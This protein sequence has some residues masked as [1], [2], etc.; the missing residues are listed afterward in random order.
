M[1]DT[2]KLQKVLARAGIASR[3]EIERW[4]DAGR[5][6]V[7]N[8]VAQLG[9]RVGEDDKIHVDDKLVKTKSTLAPRILLY[10]KP[11]GE[12]CSRGDPEGRKTIFANLPELKAARWISI[13][14][15][16]FNSAGLLLLTTDGEL[17]NKLMHP[18]NNIE[19]EYA[20]RVYGNVTNEKLTQ[21]Q[22]GVQLEDGPARFERILCGEG[23]G[24]NQ[25]YYV[26]LKE[27]RNRE[28]RRLWDS[29][30]VRVNRLLRVRYGP[31]SL[32]RHLKP[33][34]HMD[35]KKSDMNK[36]YKVAK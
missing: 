31:I 20:V 12:I 3:R 2:E 15:L 8:E 33:G 22:Q 28:V 25:W 18:S 6:R 27:G 23:E 36:L 10:H 13:G 21:L 16:D 5:I 30:G 11:E 14:R 24:K 26:I 32:P 9:C 4:I 17:A 29:Q 34:Q 19:R 1:N 7:N 35:L